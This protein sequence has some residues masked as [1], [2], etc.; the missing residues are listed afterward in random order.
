MKTAGKTGKTLRGRQK[1]ALIVGACLIVLLAIALGIVNYF[2]GLIPFTD[3]D[4][5]KYII[6]N[7][8]GVFGLYD[9]N[10]YILDTTVENKKSYFVTD[11]GTMVALSET[12]KASIYAVVDTD[13]GEVV[14]DLR[15]TVLMIFPKVESSDI[16]SL[17]ITNGTGSFTFRYDSTVGDYVIDGYENVT[18][19][20][21]KYAY[22]AAMCD[23]LAAGMKFKKE[24]VDKYGLAEY[25]LDHP[26]ASFTI[27]PKG[28]KT[29]YTVE[30]GNM[31][32]PGDGYYCRLVGRDTVYIINLSEVGN[33][34]RRMLF[35]SIESYISPQLVYGLS[36]TNYVN[37][38]NFK[39]VKYAYDGD[40]T[41]ERVET[42]LTLWPMEERQ[43]NEY[44][45]EAYKMTDPDLFGYVPNSNAV[46]ETM[47]NF[48]QMT[49]ATVAK[50]GV[51]A[52][53]LAAYGLDKPAKSLYYEFEAASG[54]SKYLMKN[55]LLF[56]ALTENG[57][58]YATS[59]VI[60]S[61]DGGKTY[62]P[63]NGFDYVVEM[64]REILPMMD[65]TS[66]DWVENYYFHRNIMTIDSVECVVNGKTILF[67]LEHGWPKGTPAASMTDQNKDVMRVVAT[68]DGESREIP[69]KQFKNLTRNLMYGVL[70]ST[71]DKT[72]AELEAIYNDPSKFQ[73]S[74]RIRT[75]VNHLD[76]TYAYHYLNE[77]T[78]YLTIDGKGEFTVM[79]FF[80]KKY[81]ADVMALWNG[82]TIDVLVN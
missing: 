6:K 57:T 47:L 23:S 51:D 54:G 38:S 60:V 3:V 15:S 20:K 10:G 34:S 21:E 16:A 17:S 32:Q 13:D 2:V 1:V 31:T 11:A 4:G 67:T 33:Y 25:G 68:M 48:A 5:T 53:T 56:S 82:E 36:T 12:G 49:G 61:R 73:F 63:M 64:P 9:Q 35:D 72:P 41:T 62:S 50:L 75:N 58:Y 74:Y 78:S 77:M 24:I 59:T 52:E 45:T 8:N 22:L 80:V 65:W 70:Y 46:A 14:S 71:A 30:I 81:A 29:R 19:D 43:N 66:V 40:T 44:Q 42:A 39:V 79:S 26:L 76:N 27:V 18:Y 69:V 37:V 55:L 28:N 7:K